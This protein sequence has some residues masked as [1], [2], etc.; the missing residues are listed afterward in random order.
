M[1]SA[2]T[3]RIATC[4]R[5]PAGGGHERGAP[6]TT[7]PAPP[8]GRRPGQ[9]LL[10]FALMMPMLL[11]MAALA[12]DVAYLYAQKRALQGAADLSA[13][14]GAAD[15]PG[16]AGAAKAAAASY[17]TKN[18]WTHAVGGVTVSIVTPYGG[19]PTR[20]E[21]TITQPAPTFFARILGIDSVDVRAR[22]VAHHE[23]GHGYAIFA[24]QSG[25]S[26][27][28]PVSAD[29]VIDWSGSFGDVKGKVHSNS[30]YKQAGSGNKVA[31]EASYA[32]DKDIAGSANT[33][34]SG[35]NKTGTQ[36]LPVTYTAADF[37]C[38]FNIPGGD[39]N[40]SGSWWAN[41]AKT[42]LKPGVYCATG[43]LK[44]SSASVTGTVT[45][46]AKG[47]NGMVQISG[48]LFDL[49]PYAKGVLV[50]SEGEGKD[51][52]VKLSGSGGTWTGEIWAGAG[53]IEASGSVNFTLKGSMIG[54]SV[55]LNGSAWGIHY[56]GSGQSRA[57]LVE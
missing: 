56:D 33:Y 15:L 41:A 18:G 11:G 6:V 37:P 5:P 25:C 10:L 16:D 44:L 12:T 19:D 52:G 22:A 29:E 2:T 7:A 27:T 28:S 40:D 54:N 45:F 57:R 55:K 42:Q 32:C 48:G 4:R 31:G 13:L 24:N 43:L 21:V 51:Y 36:S 14:A 3:P 38:T 47:A 26:T 39:I 30:G 49:E 34:S 20:I 1:Q 50:Y 9:I 53:M 8:P 23:A 35:L 17:A 46:V